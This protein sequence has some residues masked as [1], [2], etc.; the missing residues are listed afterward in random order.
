MSPKFLLLAMLSVACSFTAAQTQPDIKKPEKDEKL[1]KA[2]VSFLRET[3]ADIDR[4]RSIENRLSFS[5][6][7][8]SLMWFHDEKAA[9]AMYA[10]AIGDFKLLL[11]NLDA[12]MNAASDGSEEEL[13]GFSLFGRGR[14]TAE[15]KIAVALMVR[16]QIALGLAEHDGDMAYAFFMETGSLLSNP[17]LRESQEM[18]DKTF[19]YQLMQQIAEKDV[20]KAVKYGKQSLKAGIDDRH[21]ELLKKIYAKDTE[22]GIEFAQ[23]IVAHLRSDKEAM[24]DSWVYGGFLK[25]G[26]E[27]LAASKK[28]ESKKDPVFSESDLRAIAEQFAQILLSPEETD[29]GLNTDDQIQ[30]IEKYSPSGAAQIRKKFK[31]DGPATE[32]KLGTNAAYTAAM[33]GRGNSNMMSNTMIDVIDEGQR[34]AEARNKEFTEGIKSLDKPL[35]KEEREKTVAKARSLIS[36]TKGAEAKIASLTL[37]AAQ[38]AKAGD[39]ELA[40]EIM[41]EAD[42]LVNPLPKNYRD[43]LLSWLLASSYA[44]SDPEK[45]FPLLERTIMRANETLAAFAKVAEFIDVNEEMISDGEVQVGAF[46]GSMLRGM[47]RELGIANT[48]LISLA[49]ADFGKMK[50]VTETFDR[51]E[52]RVLAKM[53][54]LRALLDEKKPDPP[55]DSPALPGMDTS[56]A[57]N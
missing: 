56:S 41:Q 9:R 24:K 32:I 34:E 36:K 19:E 7:L 21:L 20:S 51:L 29:V 44:E 22:K 16:Q 2:A 11:I 31:I 13:L 39:R 12:R 49:K 17:T 8:A 30:L 53:L 6:E 5:S 18:A 15:R 43:Y 50:A 3:S 57:A 47:T 40:A 52:V 46:G 26:N 45:A 37:L 1:I 14:S 25:Y 35:S 54:V 27:I 4:M 42:K 10:A 38:V 48:T 23:A 33:A 55:S 28:S